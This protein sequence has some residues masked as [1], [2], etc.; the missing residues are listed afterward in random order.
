MPAGLRNIF[1]LFIKGKNKG[2]KTVDHEVYKPQGEHG[3]HRTEKDP[4]AAP[5][6]IQIGHHVSYPGK[7]CKEHEYK[8]ENAVQI[9]YGK[10]TGYIVML[11]EKTPGYIHYKVTVRR[12]EK[13]VV[14]DNCHLPWLLIS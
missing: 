8:I 7:H 4:A 1:M 5:S 3:P 9:Q 10:E 14:A 12:H 13:M 2:M 11:V 6:F